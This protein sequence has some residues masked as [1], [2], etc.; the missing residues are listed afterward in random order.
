F[1]KDK[2][3]NGVLNTIANFILKDL[4]LLQ[5][6]A[7]MGQQVLNTALY[8]KEI[9]IDNR[10][11]DEQIWSMLRKQ[12][13][14]KY[15]KMLKVN[16]RTI[17][18]AMHFIKQEM[19]YDTFNQA[20]HW[21][22]IVIN[23]IEGPLKLVVEHLSSELVC[24]DHLKPIVIQ[25]E[26]AQCSEYLIFF[27]QTNE[28]KFCLLDTNS[29]TSFREEKFITPGNFD[30]S[31]IFQALRNG[32]GGSFSKTLLNTTLDVKREFDTW[33][34]I[35][36]AAK[37]DDSL[38]LRF[39]M[40][41]TWNLL[42][43]NQD[44]RNVLE[45]A[46]ENASPQTISA[47][48][49]LPIVLENKNVLSEEQKQ[50]LNLSDVDETPLTIIAERG[51]ASTL[52]F[53]IECGIDINRRRKVRGQQLRLIDLAWNG[54]RYDNVLALL[55]AD[56]FYPSE[57]NPSTLEGLE[58]A[59][60]LK[61]FSEEVAQ[62][63]QALRE[64]DK[65]R[66]VCFTEHHPRLKKVC[67]QNNQSALITAL[68]ARQFEAF[69][70]LQSKGFICAQNEDLVLT[71]EVLNVQEKEELKLIKLKYFKKQHNAHI[72]FLL[73]KSKVYHEGILQEPSENHVSVIQELF[74][75]LDNIAETS[76]IM[77]VLEHAQFVQI[78]FCFNTNAVSDQNSRHPAIIANSKTGYLYIDAHDRGRALHLL[79]KGL[80]HLAIQTVYRNN[81]KPYTS[82]DNLAERAFM[83]I[84]DIYHSRLE[85]LDPIIRDIINNPI[86][87]NDWQSELI[88]CVPILLVCYGKRMLEMKK[89]LPELF[90]FYENHIQKHFMVFIDEYTRIG[91]E[92]KVQFLNDLL[93]ELDKIQQSKIWLKKHL[94][95][96]DMF[97]PCTV[98]V[99]V[100]N[101]P[102]LAKSD[103]YQTL[104]S[105]HSL[106]DVKSNYIFATSNHL[107]NRRQ[108][109]EIYSMHRL[110]IKP[111]LIVDCSLDHGSNYQN[112]WPTINDFLENGRIMLIMKEPPCDVNFKKV[113]TVN[114]Y[115]KWKDLGDDTR[116]FIQ[117]KSIDFQG[118]NVTLQELAIADTPITEST[119]LEMLL[120]NESIKI[121]EPLQMPFGF[122]ESY[123]IKR[124]FI[125]QLVIEDR[126]IEDKE[127]GL[128]SDHLAYSK[129]EFR[130]LCKEYPESRIHWLSKERS[131]QLI[132]KE[133]R[134]STQN[135]N[136]YISV[137]NQR[138]FSSENVEDL[139][140]QAQRQR[141]MI[142]SDSAGMG[143]TTILAHLSKKIKAI[144][145]TYWVCLLNLNI[146]TEELE[147]QS[148]EQKETIEFIVEELLKLSSPF[149]TAV[150]KQLLSTKRVILMFDG[151]DEICPL[152]ETVVT[153]LLVAL[154]NTS[155]EQIWI[156]TRPHLQSY[157]TSE[158]E[159][160]L[161]RLTPFSQE[162][163]INFLVRFWRKK[164][165]IVT[166]NES[167]MRLYARALLDK[168]SGSMNDK[169]KVFAGIPLQTRL[170]AEAFLQE[171]SDYYS[172]K[173]DVISNLPNQLDIVDTYTR[174]LRCKYQIYVKEKGRPPN[175]TVAA[176][177]LLRILKGENL[178]KLHQQL[179]LEILFPQQQ[180][181]LLKTK[182]M[183]FLPHDQISRIGIVQYIGSKVYFAHQ[184]FA[185]YYVADFFVNQLLNPNSSSTYIQ[186][187]LLKEILLQGNLQNIR[188]FFDGLISKL[189]NPFQQAIL[190]E[191]G[192]QIN[193][194]WE[195]NSL[196]WQESN[197]LYIAV[198]ERNSL[199]VKFLLNCLK[200]GKYT[201]TLAELLLD[202]TN[203][204]RSDRRRTVLYQA[205]SDGFLD[206]L[207]ILRLW[208]TEA[209]LN[210]SSHF[211]RLFLAKDERSISVWHEIAKQGHADVFD[212]LYD[213]AAKVLHSSELKKI[214]CHNDMSF[215]T[216]WHHAVSSGN[217]EIIEKLW[218]RAKQMN[219]EPEYIR[220]ILL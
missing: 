191:Y 167:R 211:I 46:A 219:L 16:V 204:N 56:S 147:K 47:L 61:K 131:G 57:Y 169:G 210:S 164:A 126:I 220:E 51:K 128:I 206:M 80:A 43:R 120:E 2:S 81:S 71:Y 7:N 79:A 17:Q 205:A 130:K 41:F 145:P 58:Q 21:F 198:E 215:K 34:L 5:K 168:L 119:P 96:F 214:F 136:K 123:Y 113:L 199:I 19:F 87:I 78:I 63:H 50:L 183:H 143:K 92:R 110:L 36:Y 23:V 140:E 177:D 192:D 187:F 68:E 64:D 77:K 218:F 166:K 189:I 163:Q 124:T 39:L 88:V 200:M 53:L 65:D 49:D 152:Y 135:L 55:Q 190:T 69:V 83:E 157:L 121:G 101:S 194:L 180:E 42:E 184:T 40:L 139:L 149:E 155:V 93:G 75:H 193:E 209:R 162:D 170:L 142:I 118:H 66:I 98:T 188:I 160:L 44:G 201:K 52:K 29:K 171:F 112:L 103:L 179:A 161:Y 85:A 30:F 60:A 35:D 117:Q 178:R 54:Q 111:M 107:K 216:V 32:I 175:V 129:T 91:C 45:I 70:L 104:I 185:E 173:T 94:C 76:T 138:N 10:N 84:I 165:E 59:V 15:F 158:L 174:F 27:R 108:A 217:L 67:N 197:I 8:L 182:K 203:Y 25:W 212:K 20:T 186:N 38:S 146:Y 62:F 153:K 14:N 156:S 213:W 3:T 195:T 11:N 137:K 6:L 114:K 141:I 176:K 9:F 116:T 202:G 1:Q 207:D 37:N 73:S 97:H 89:H 134:G 82:C 13:E 122:D 18:T 144:Y 48:L 86:N 105:K 99:I 26:S 133:S 154:R 208:A 132:W 109:Q 196:R 4:L 172:S 100:S 102:N 90:A 24:F 12:R 28:H 33:R 115:Y 148:N 74:E 181:S 95:D 151:F 159:Q 127:D 72:M 125:S 106:I 31:L 22:V 150:F